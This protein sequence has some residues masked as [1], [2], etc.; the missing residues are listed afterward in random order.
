MP[1]EFVALGD[2][3]IAD[4]T[5]LDSARVGIFLARTVP[6]SDGARAAQRALRSR[7]RPE[8]LQ[9]APPGPH[10]GRISRQCPRGRGQVPRAARALQAP[11]ERKG[12][13]KSKKFVAQNGPRWHLSTHATQ[14]PRAAGE[15]CPPTIPAPAFAAS[16]RAPAARSCSRSQHPERRGLSLQRPAARLLDSRALRRVRGPLPAPRTSTA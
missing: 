3:P 2:L 7:C 15:T 8:G 16:C 6:S 11:T 12:F 4:W 14:I 10:Q 1:G 9:Q 5:V 13:R